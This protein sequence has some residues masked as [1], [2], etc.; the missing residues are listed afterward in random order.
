MVQER[1]ILVKIKP[2]NYTQNHIRT[3]YSW[4]YFMKAECSIKRK[5]NKP[6]IWFGRI[7]IYRIYRFYYFVRVKTDVSISF[8]VW[9]QI[10]SSWHNHS[11]CGQMFRLRQKPA[12]ASTLDKTVNVNG[13]L[14]NGSEHAHEL[15]TCSFFKRLNRSEYCK[16]LAMD[17]ETSGILSKA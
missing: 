4:C 2:E 10:D 11:A 5:V 8:F 17:N 9:K 3:C 7:E 15:H 14:L 6:V 13:L 16:E 12:C 1:N